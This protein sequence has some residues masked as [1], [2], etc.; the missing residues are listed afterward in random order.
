MKSYL[1]NIIVLA[2][3]AVMATSANADSLTLSTN[4]SYSVL[5]GGAFIAKINNGPISNADYSGVAKIGSDSFLT[6]CIEYNEHFS[7]PGTY[8]YALNTGAVNGGVSGQ[9]S[10][11]FDP[12]SNGTAFLYSK[13]AQGSLAGVA[14]F[15]YGKT[16]TGY[17]YLQN[18]I[19]FLEGEITTGN[20]LSSYV[21]NNVANYNAASNGAAG[22]FA[23]NL[24]DA[25]GGV[26]QDQLYY[27]NVPDQ[28]ATV[29]LLGLGLLCM[30][31][32]RRRFV[33]AK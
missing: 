13:F 17:G 4:N 10:P 9:T 28:G 31:G 7:S 14:G 30:V 3:L 27:R 2:S 11:N 18:A 16:S 5:P 33:S 22:V 32:L 1:K 15:T 19:W 6:F 23:L 25:A 29:A 21:I 8:N 24:T 12:I 20:A 26:H